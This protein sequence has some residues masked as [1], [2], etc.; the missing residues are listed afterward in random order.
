MNVDPYV[1][2]I[3]QD[4]SVREPHLYFVLVCCFPPVRKGALRDISHPV[5]LV[6][7]NKIH[8]FYPTSS[9]FTLTLIVELDPVV[10]LDLVMALL[11]PFSDQALISPEYTTYLY[12]RQALNYTCVRD[13]FTYKEI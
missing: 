9:S 2:L 6:F 3:K 10:Y 11:L 5:D 8:D 12:Y 7:L 1:L 4:L 13:S